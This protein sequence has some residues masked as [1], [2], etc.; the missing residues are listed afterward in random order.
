MVAIVSGNGLGLLNGSAGVLGQQG[1]SG[2]AVHGNSK[3][4]AYLN[5]AN[6]NLVLQDSDDFL[7]A[8]GVNVA[9][10]RTYNSQGALNDGNGAN[11]K[12]GL[13]KQV[14][15]LVGTVNTAGSKVYR[16]AGDGSVALFSYNAAKAA[17]LSNDG[18]GAYQS[19]T[20]NAAANEWTW[21]GDRNDLL[22]TYE[23]YDGANN[24]RVVRAG[25]AVGIRQKYA[26]NAAGQLAQVTDAV[27]KGDAAVLAGDAANDANDQ[28][29]FDYDAAGNL[30]Q[31]RHVLAGTD[32]APLRSMV[33]TRYGYDALHRL[34]SVSVDLSSVGCDQNG[35]VQ[36]NAANNNIDDGDAYTTTYTYDGDSNRVAGLVQSDGS[37]LAITYKQVGADWKADS[38]TDALGRKTS[39]DYSVP[40]KATVTDPLG[41]KTTYGFDALGQLKDI[42]GPVVNGA[43]QLTTFGYDANGNVTSITD[44]RGTTV[45]RYDANGNRIYERNPAGAVVSR[46]YE[47]AN[48]RLL[49]EARYIQPDPDGDGAGAPSN[50]SRTSYA[51]DA[52]GRL[53]YVVAPDMGL[54][55]YRYN[56]NGELAAELHYVDKAWPEQA[57]TDL[58]YLLES[59]Y[60]TAVA[61]TLFDKTKVNRTDYTYDARGLLRSATRYAGTTAAG[62]GIADGSQSVTRYTYDQAGRLLYSRDGNGNLSSNVYDGLGRLLSQTNAQGT[63][64]KSV[65]DGHSNLSVTTTAAGAGRASSSVSYVRDNAGQLLS[66]QSSFADGAA[67]GTTANAYDADGRLRMSTDAAGLRT[68]WLYDEAG[69]KVAQI[70]AN[71]VLT[72]YVYNPNNQVTKT[73][74]YGTTVD[75]AA[76]V[77]GQGRPSAV[78]LA[79]L[80]PAAA[81]AAD[82]SEW[83][84]YDNGGRLVASVDASGFL[85]RMVYDS[86]DR[87][88]SVWYRAKPI[89]VTK[90]DGQTIPAA[91]AGE[92]TAL[93]DRYS[94]MMY[95][96]AGR[97]VGVLD[98][99]G[100]LTENRYDPAGRLVETIKYDYM[101]P[102]AQRN[103]G[104]LA[105]MR[106]AATPTDSH[107]RYLY[108]GKDQLV[109]SIDADNFLTE[110]SY[111]AAGN[112]ASRRRYANAVTK[113]AGRTMAELGATVSVDDRITSY[114]YTVLNQVA[115]ETSLSGAF[116]QYQYDAA[117]NV[118]AV[119]RGLA[120]ADDST[121]R[122]R[123][124][125]AGRLVAELNEDGAARL[126]ALGAEPEPAAVA[127]VWAVYAQ[128]YNYDSAGRRTSATDVQG[129]RSL[130][131]YDAMGRR[132][133][134][135]N[136]LGEV[137]EQRYDNFNQVVKT[138]QYAKRLDAATLA[139]LVGGAPDGAF[140][141]AVA[142]LSDVSADRRAV[143]Y[144]DNNGRL[145]HSIDG[146]GHVKGT[147][148]NAYGQVKLEVDYAGNLGAAALAALG[149]GKIGAQLGGAGD[150]AARQLDAIVNS[151]V[152]NQR[153]L[154]YYDLNGHL[155][156]TVN[157]LGEVLGH[158]YYPVILTHLE[159]VTRY[160][161][162]HLPDNLNGDSSEIPVFSGAA[163]AAAAMNSVQ[164][165][166]YNMRGQLADL[167][168]AGGNHTLTTYNAFGEVSKVVR[169]AT[170]GSLA[171]A[172]ALDAIV[173][174]LYDVDGRVR[175]T[176]DGAGAVT[177][178]RY[179]GAGH[180]VDKIG[181]ANP[182]KG[183]ATSTNLGKTFDDA[184][185][186]AELSDPARDIHQRFVYAN[187]K[188]LAT[189]NAQQVVAQ[190]DA[191]N[192]PLGYTSKWAVSKQSYD[193]NGRPAGNTGYAATLDTA[194]A[195]PSDESVR[196]WLA[197]VERRA[198]P[199]GAD[200]GVRLLRDAIGRVVATATAQRGADNT[201]EW[202]VV[203]QDYDAAGNVA[204]RTAYATALKSAEPSAAEIAAVAASPYDAVTVY[205]YDGANRVVMSATAQGPGAGQPAVQQ[206][207]VSR[208]VYD[209]AGN[210]V[211]RTQFGP[212]LRMNPP[213]LDQNGAAV[214]LA[215][216]VVD[217][218]L[219]DRNTRIL[220][221]AANRPVV[222]VDANGTIS[223]QLYD[224]K[225]N[226]VRSVVYGQP[227]GTPALVA[228]DYNP[229]LTT[230]DHV[231]RTVFDANNRPVYVVDPL[232]LATEYRYDVLGN[233]AAKVRY[234]TPLS[235]ANLAAVAKLP[236]S[237]GPAEAKPLLP[238]AGTGDQTERYAYDQE[239]RLRYTVDANGGLKE[240]RY[241]ALGQVAAKLEYAKPKTFADP[242][243]LAA[244]DAEALAQSAGARLN[245]FLYDAAGRLRASIDATNAV[246]A[247]QYD[248]N[249]NLVDKIGYAGF[250]N[251]AYTFDAALAAGILGDPLRDTH[252]RFVYDAAGNLVATLTAQS[253]TSQRD[254]A[255]SV[256]Y[257]VKWAVSKQTRDQFGRVT[258]RTGYAWLMDSASRTPA[259]ADMLQWIAAADARAVNDPANPANQGAVSDAT[260]RMVYDAAGRLAAT[261]T[262]QRR[263]A[264]GTIEWSLVRQDY[265]AVGNLLVRTAYANT[266]T[267]A[268]PSAAQ[269]LTG[270]AASASDA[271]TRYNY[272][273]MNRVVVTATAQGPANDDDPTQRWAL[274]RLSY[275]AY[276]NVV[277]RRQFGTLLRANTPPADLGAAVAENDTLDRL[278]RTIYDADNRPVVSIDAAG[279]IS[280]VVYDARGNA[281][282][283]IA[284]AATT[285]TP[286]LVTAA[287]G[288]VPGVDERVSRTVYDLED[289]PVYDIDALGQLT[290][291]RYDALGN[292]TATIRYAAALAADLLAKITPQSTAA[293]AKA[294]LP[295][296]TAQ[297]RVERYT[298]DQERRL[299]YTV[300]AA[301]YLKENVYNPLGQLSATREYLVP[302]NQSF[303]DPMLAAELDAP[304]SGQRL[305]QSVRINQFDYDLAGRL[306]SST[307]SQLASEKYGYDGLGRKTSFTNKANQTWTYEYDAAGRLTL[308][309]SPLVAVYAYSPPTKMGEWGPGQQLAMM[310]RLE[311]DALGN[312]SKR[313]EGAG[314]AT[315]R[316]TEYRYDALGRQTRTI[317]PSARIYDA[318][319][320]PKS[321][322]GAAAR[323]DPDTDSGPRVTRVAYDAFGNAVSNTDVGGKTSYKVYDKHGQVRFDID[324]MGFVTGYLRDS[325]GNVAFLTRYA[326]S[327]GLSAAQIP[328]QVADNAFA[329][330]LGFAA[331][332]RTV[333][334]RY[335][336]LD[337]VVKVI[338]PTTSIFDQH[339][340]GA[341]PELSAAK[342]TDTAYTGFGEVARQDV[343]G[344]GA[345]GNRVTDAAGTR[346]GYDARG[347]KTSQFAVLTAAADGKSGTG[348]LSTYAYAYD[349]DSKGSRVTQTEFAGTYAWKDGVAEKL[350][351]P[352]G[353]PDRSTVT[354]YDQEKRLISETRLN[355]SHVENGV[356]KSGNLST[357]YG[358][359][360]L[361]RQ[362][363][364]TDAV[365]STTFTYYD[366][367]GRTVAVAKT[368][369]PGFADIAAAGVPLTEF[370]LDLLGNTVLRV[371]YAQGLAGEVNA[372]GYTAPTGAMAADANNRV[373]ATR[374]DTSGHAVATLD[375]EQ[376]AQGATASTINTSYDI[377][378]RVAKQWRSVTGSRPGASSVTQTA[379]QINRYDDLG[380]LLEVETPGNENLVDLGAPPPPSTVKRN[381]YNAFG[382]L[383][384]TTV[385]SGAAAAQTTSYTR[386]DQAG[387]AWL[388]NSGDGV[389]KVTLFDAL[390]HAT[391]QIVSTSNAQGADANPLG[392]LQSPAQLA[393]MAEL[394]RTNTRYD[395]LGNILDQ[396]LS[397][398]SAIY[399]LSK[400][401]ATG[402]WNQTPLQNANQL[403]DSLVVLGAANDLSRNM[404][405]QFRLLGG[406]EWTDQ[407]ATRVQVLGDYLAFNTA[408]MAAGQYEYRISLRP[409]NE[410]S[411][412]RATGT[413]TISALPST[414]KNTQL[415]RAYVALLRR[416]PDLPGMNFYVG[417]LNKGESLA[418]LVNDFLGSTEAADF[419][420]LTA[421]AN[422]VVAA[423]LGDLGRGAG[424]DVD[425]NADVGRWATLYDTARRVGGDA[426]AQ[427]LLDLIDD[428]YRY[429]GQAGARLAAKARLSN[430]VDATLSYALDYRGG[431]AD[432]AKQIF[433]LATTRRDDALQ[434]AK[435]L[436]TTELRRSQIAQLY[437]TL[438]GRAPEQGGMNAWLDAMTKGLNIEQVAVGMLDSVEAKD[439]LLYPSDG[440]SAADYRLQLIR[441]SY[442]TMLGRPVTAAEEA[443]W[444]GK[445]E[446]TKDK[447]AISKGL[448]ALQLADQVASYAGT[449]SARLAEKLQFN[450]RLAIALTFAQQDLAAIP[451]ENR[452]MVSKALMA[453]LGS[454]ASAQAAVEMA[455]SN[456]ATAA[457]VAGVLDTVVGTAANATPMENMRLQLS[458]LY[459]VL[460]NRT[461]DTTGLNYQIQNLLSSAQGAPSPARWT[462]L[463][464]NLLTSA[465]ARN[466]P[467]LAGAG[468]NDSQFV[469][470]LYALALGKT[471][472][473]VG[474]KAEMAA[475]VAQL[476]SKSRGEIAVNITNGL[477]SFNG[478]SADEVALKNTYNNKVAVSLACAIDL[479]AYDWAA[480]ND[481]LAGRSVLALVS[482]S[483]TKAALDFAYGK[484]Q[485]SFRLA[486]AGLTAASTKAA[487]ALQ[488]A[489]AAA[490]AFE[491]AK[492]AVIAASNAAS[493][494]PGAAGRL[495]LMQLY[496]GL[497]GRD[498]QYYANNPDLVGLDFQAVRLA[499]SDINTVAQGFLTSPDGAARY[500][501]TMSDQDFVAK[502]L[503]TVLGNNT[504]GLGYVT[505]WTAKLAAPSAMSRGQVA[506]GILNQLLNYENYTPDAN[507]KALLQAKQAFTQRV[508]KT[509]AL[510]DVAQAGV[511]ANAAAALAGQ[512]APAGTPQALQ[513]AM[514]STAKA[515][516]DATLAYNNAIA[517][518]NGAGDGSAAMRLQV[519]R[520]YATLMK[521]PAAPSL[522]EL[523][524]Q[525]GSGQPLAAIAQG[526][527]NGN[528]ALAQTDNKTFV[529]NLYQLILGRAA[530]PDEDL[531]VWT[532]QLGANTGE[533][534]LRGRIAVDILNAFLAYSDATTAQLANKVAFDNKISGFLAAEKVAADKAAT[535]ANTELSRLKGLTATA[536]AKSDAATKALAPLR[537]AAIEPTL[538]L[539]A[540]YGQSMLDLSAYQREVTT[541]YMA[542]RGYTDV[543]GVVVQ[544]RALAA[545]GITTTNIVRDLMAAN[546][547]PADNAGFVTRLYKEVLHRAPE[548][549]A[550]PH[551]VPIL[552]GG[553]TR[554]QVAFDFILSDEAKTLL[555]ARVDPQVVA[556]IGIAKGY[557][558][559]RETA[560]GNYD[561]ANNNAIAV[562]TAYEAALAAQVRG[563]TAVLAA[564][565]LAAGAAALVTAHNSVA[566][567]DGAA[568]AAAKAR[569]NYAL[570]LR[571]SAYKALQQVAAADKAG[572]TLAGANAALAGAQLDVANCY[573]GDAA[574]PA[575]ERQSRQVGQLF[576]LLLNRAPLL[577]ELSFWSAKLAAGVQ[578]AEIA[579]SI[580]AGADAAA[581]YPPAM[582]NDAFV[583]QLF[584]FGLNRDFAKDPVGLRFW[585]DKLG[586]AS[587]LSRAQLAANW[588]A[589]VSLAGTA[590]GAS[591]AKRTATA[592]LATVAEGQSAPNLMPAILL[593]EADAKRTANEYDGVAAANVGKVATAQYVKPLAQ[594]YVAL[595]NRAPDA[596][597]LASWINTLSRPQ[598]STLLQVANGIITSVEGQRLYPAGLSNHDFVQ[599]VMGYMTGR[600]VTEAE[601]APYVAQ[602]AGKSRGEVALNLIASLADAPSADLAQMSTRFV[603]NGKVTSALNKVADEAARGLAASKTLLTLLSTVKAA[604]PVDLHVDGVVLGVVSQ[605]QAGNKVETVVNSR[606]VDRWGNVLS[607]T[608][609]RDP[610]WSIRYTYNQDNQLIDQTVNALK[611]ASNV[612]HSSTGY[613]A[614]GR[615][616]VTTDY[617]GYA[618]RVGYDAN[619][620]VALE[621][622][623]DGGKVNYTYSLFGNR[624]SVSQE[625]GYGLTAQTTR[626]AYDHLG[627]LSKSW[628]DAA[629]VS[630]AAT[631]QHHRE[632]E[633]KA[634]AAAQL[635]QIFA[636]DEM[637]RNVART[638]AAGG[639]SYLGYDLDGNV[640]LNRNETGRETV[641]AYDAFHNRVAMRDAVGNGM[642]WTANN[643]GRALT[644][645]SVAL[646]GGATTTVYSYDAAGQKIRQTCER[647]EN[648]RQDIQYVYEKGL[649]TQVRDNGTG[650]TTN[651]TYD[652]VGN[653]LTEKQSFNGGPLGTE[654]PKQM[655]NNTMSYD[656]QNR[657]A[658][659]KDDV[660]TLNYEYDANGNRTH[661][662]TAYDAL[663]PHSHRE[664]VIDGNGNE[665]WVDV[666]DAPTTRP[667]LI[668]S[669]NSY[670]E[671]NRQ[672]VVNGDWVDG[673]AVYGKSGH[674][675]SYDKAGN[676]MTDTFIGKKIHATALTGFLTIP[677]S[678]AYSTEDNQET[679]ESY[680]Y[681]NAGRLSDILR[682]GVV[683][684]QRHYDQAGRMAES[685]ILYRTVNR[686]LDSVAKVVGASDVKHTYAYNLAGQMLEQR[687]EKYDQ[688]NAVGELI[689]NVYFI[690][691]EGHYDAVGN[692]LNYTVSPK[693]RGP[694]ENYNYSVTYTYID[695]QYKEESKR[696][697]RGATNISHYDVNGNRTSVTE[698]GSNKVLS[699]L[700][701][702]ADGHVQSKREA[703]GGT[704]FSL[705]VNGQ[706]LG[707]ETRTADN[708]LGSIY[709][710]VSSPSLSAPP[711]TY[712]VQG[713]SETLQ[714]I[715]RNLW[716]DSKL[717]YLI[718]DANGLDSDSK[719]AAGQILNIPMRVNTI[720]NDYAT[721]K[722]YDAAEALG[723]TTPAPPPP[724]H[725]G[726]CG[727]VGTLIMVV[728]AIAVTYV[729]AGAAA[730]A[731][732]AATGGLGSVATT[733]AISTT[734][735][736]LSTVAGA[737]I[738]GAVGSI[739]S[740][741]VGMAIGAQDG[742]NWKGVA[743]AALGGAITAGV[744]TMGATGQLGSALKGVDWTD[745]AARAA[746]SNVVTQG[747]GNITGLQHGFNWS[748]VAASYAGAAVGSQVTGYLENQNIFGDLPQ[749]AARF[750]TAGISS[751]SAGLTTA[752]MR[753]GKIAVAQIATDAF[754]NALGSSLAENMS[755]V[756]TTSRP[757]RETNSVAPMEWAPLPVNLNGIL[758]AIPAVTENTPG[759]D[760]FGN[761]GGYDPDDLIENGLPPDAQFIDPP[762]GRAGRSIATTIKA[763]PHLTLSDVGDYFSG[764]ASST[765]RSIKEF[766]TEDIPNMPSAIVDFAKHPLESLE[767][768][769]LAL[770]DSARKAALDAR[771]GNFRTAGE[772][773]GT[774]IGKSIAGTAFGVGTGMVF[775]RAAGLYNSIPSAFEPVLIPDI[776][777][778]GE[779]VP[780]GA[781]GDLIGGLKGTGLQAHHANQNAAY[782]SV[783]PRNEGFSIGLRGNAF[784]EVGSP[785]FEA[786]SAL[787][788][789]WNDYRKGGVSF[790]ET[791]TNAQYG[792]AVKQSFE[793]AGIRSYEAQRLSD[794][795]ARS[796]DAYGLKATDPVPNI[797]R[798]INQSG[799]K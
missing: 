475:Y 352:A 424:D 261:A 349:P 732:F 122:A 685:G 222:T 651:Y 194:G 799:R 488:N 334:T 675:I 283:R 610:N 553:R 713:A 679:V 551:W 245:S 747:V 59:N 89:D 619:G 147:T 428:T 642:R 499:G 409:D 307:D 54:T 255:D 260:V 576:Q 56:A 419:H 272:D 753:G 77:D 390:G 346:Y 5:I 605:V 588:I 280:R 618:N 279:A 363:S 507:G 690:D 533:A 50:A 470:R 270:V 311:Y 225:G 140:G 183:Y 271:V 767:K 306:S 365:G 155:I 46:V 231:T 497:L 191:Q 405:V 641:Y 534:N 347:N 7:A 468:L 429:A 324:A 287:Y 692:V 243:T 469:E 118:V 294:L 35:A 482:A 668:D 158:G 517:T 156:Y 119:T 377:Y 107:Q 207:A 316:V 577:T 277:N 670:D 442:Q 413:W 660:Y 379:F 563:N 195:A 93:D 315:P 80:R 710:G 120:G 36:L 774:M 408:G 653:R 217:N 34:R 691:K 552:S 308:E 473:S 794:L 549:A 580:L 559:A 726:G 491:L 11:W 400:D 174:T 579:A 483:D 128:H 508:A 729:T 223:A 545:G 700:W 751:F 397:G 733:A 522:G 367:L 537:A 146:A 735:G 150:A 105:A 423:I 613:D 542:L 586:G 274:T 338:E 477:L 181:Y 439:P 91:I 637:G 392:K 719:L 506:F 370:K 72:E 421:A 495:Q 516:A 449:D 204:V 783:I 237:A 596:A 702:D 3:E 161:A 357:S 731:I 633:A 565:K 17:Y 104:N 625:R 450:N 401:A 746:V 485:A 42:S 738:G 556:D 535:D 447:P 53:H 302:L 318:A 562:K 614:L 505:E 607:V 374:Y 529:A 314:S 249:G 598:G 724:Q 44:P 313:T 212:L 627:H 546:N 114:S 398:D 127:A 389:D 79:A 264:N 519:T 101:T 701:Y 789:F 295:Q 90:L 110:T 288:L 202:A 444:R 310:T 175:A 182:L 366:A 664:S 407:S 205:N 749:G 456:A 487:A 108:N 354:V 325:F 115:R 663:V 743:M 601:M 707:E 431:S 490:A 530:A 176:V 177:A 453:A 92:L 348:Y 548:A 734:M 748:S 446:G 304:A 238:K 430:R 342:T 164:Q 234:A 768:G 460:L 113:P 187:G 136:A 336:K 798:K 672:L 755:G 544:M 74:R 639:T 509:F 515:Q 425:F 441:T 15:G 500:P 296:A 740:Q 454:A 706:V 13:V 461:L 350:L 763:S 148:Y 452:G 230:A 215:G 451:L 467:T 210:V 669:H 268:D 790:G 384:A 779:M 561:A 688:N 369:A 382:E 201:V 38:I 709:T 415:A 227:T 190:F 305:Q 172:P 711:A 780:A 31:I 494:A 438:F 371:E 121:S 680:Q 47:L 345:A 151:K 523:N 694:W 628:S 375:A 654:T 291:R 246:T 343:Y 511:V 224:A 157:P 525:I 63:V 87:M 178:F 567:A 134:T 721:F 730:Q 624:L 193:A 9:L 52:N 188:L 759:Q 760:L 124:D 781:Y 718:A 399:V 267:A 254:S 479:G 566:T 323:V 636:F 527:I 197:S 457:T 513:A 132:S 330:A 620:N 319:N 126:A 173:Q 775:S 329:N 85:K 687:D 754:G 647:G 432:T 434:L 2:N 395:L 278:T 770:Q 244:L 99:M 179:D 787:E 486:S 137:Q 73:T 782:S 661:V 143:F 587:P 78:T 742:F 762:V 393:G 630:Y 476:G 777:N 6:G 645:T 19:M 355:A 131:Y 677:G 55:E 420:F 554:E 133:H 353:A 521:Y 629:V 29:Y 248:V 788:S 764:M 526:M 265:D 142:A 550:L 541:L 426:P 772:L 159:T 646:V 281:V 585:S 144:Y 4:A 752:V 595:L 538:V 388:S 322:A 163:N 621:S 673:K 135:V 514:A 510:V 186:R 236:M 626:Y 51:Y 76:L 33:R 536:L 547:Y 220:Y 218:D 715:A 337:R 603:Y 492:G 739:A 723:D 725:G 606:T 638:D 71:G 708:I 786:H 139:A 312:L 714:S 555:P 648:S 65:Y 578:P 512:T 773:E 589:V 631:S 239:R 62:E 199:A 45:Y 684:N 474:A 498:E 480:S 213:L 18:A 216:K 256:G 622:H 154:Y 416:G 228:A 242:L 558:A 557:I 184:M 386:Y 275:D 785:H 792:Q 373:T 632:L 600:A 503:A 657:L 192:K 263:G 402:N 604:K 250:L 635:V 656:E 206:W 196:L 418:H 573:V 298:Y 686:G 22:G 232:G 1:I 378:G 247:F 235:D 784:T 455:F 737:A 616:A 341:S 391:A 634:M 750:A 233:V 208:L 462:E 168:D 240:T 502:V 362:T 165:L 427:V 219:V 756:N 333:V 200:A 180:V 697:E 570:S 258:A 643:Y 171:A 360:K 666:D 662:R 571:F 640:V 459:V 540:G 320:D 61:G 359:D 327:K 617:R 153:N 717:W 417:R 396:R 257:A 332:D 693:D 383:T 440:L 437:L 593:A 289:R 766:V 321:S 21:R 339:S 109:G 273:D 406:A 594:L 211:R 678:V 221:D 771:D 403:G 86:L 472:T 776:F 696:V 532:K 189:L 471:P 489:A 493:A 30:G 671:M 241:N 728:V 484:S 414:E 765:G 326:A 361:G 259:A 659:V 387:R 524:G 744:G 253:T 531:S 75:T 282:Q 676:R 699:T 82:R 226:V 757:V 682:D 103:S 198:A 162:R 112:V 380:R 317:L 97:L 609:A 20:F 229:A 286:A 16:T 81:L 705:I 328:A 650:M 269:I 667:E 23:V 797:P 83:N 655:Q 356:A 364:T 518:A 436:G 94:R 69:R 335:D 32:A 644:S 716:G 583:T 66:V 166:N 48:N 12:Y 309:T 14:G 720:H 478:Q 465:E 340:I 683:V 169:L 10:T 591:F 582:G 649:L 292:V 351:T 49:A 129:N 297:D 141:N 57:W 611:G 27:G 125:D 301:G 41:F 88:V 712:S 745:V 276:G 612:A 290:E 262:A 160:A 372:A 203:R 331:D 252:Q 209:S 496:V 43:S 741:V 117:G 539:K 64:V 658:S 778:Y 590:D 674:K 761:R 293:T 376:F 412:E 8:H 722:P 404:Q 385:R 167:T 795:A 703:D 358:Y 615:V 116:T 520:L 149:G 793:Q 466:D 300:D 543:P 26:Y 569:D 368:Q 433:N 344:A 568:V 284:Y 37:A 599:Q 584:R 698:Q 574:A 602:L 528:P 608:D 299:R 381:D 285:D 60:N 769:G 100:F 501:A 68:F 448:F 443:D 39:I 25:D 214:D 575:A 138:I 130:Y 145:T 445:L 58:T 422:S 394:R 98:C 123:F 170:A 411:F 597:G 95:D 592:L 560:I 758:D 303:A 70:E 727:G 504:L 681:D 689:Q 464:N 652:L 458:R 96:R 695:G 410:P 40:N 266:L 84:S 111:D 185:A 564:A 581:L 152:G 435:E 102:P 736:A 28:T 665:S 623:A 791:P 572:A 106:P 796:R 463:A 251:P 67:V 481:P 24:G 704:H